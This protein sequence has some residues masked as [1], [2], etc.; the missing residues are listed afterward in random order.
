VTEETIL[1]W[2]GIQHSINDQAINKWQNRLNAR[3]K[4]KGKHFEHLF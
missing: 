4:A 1:A 3:V 2:S